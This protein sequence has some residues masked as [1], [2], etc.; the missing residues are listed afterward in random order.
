MQ[1]SSDIMMTAVNQ[2]DCDWIDQGDEL[3][4]PDIHRILQEGKI[5]SIL[6]KAKKR[7]FEACFELSEREM[8]IRQVKGT[9]LYIKA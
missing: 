5:T 6:N 7:T 2:Y 8:K 4:I 9:L 3:K 1:R